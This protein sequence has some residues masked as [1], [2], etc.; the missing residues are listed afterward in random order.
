MPAPDPGV[1]PATKIV[2]LNVTGT[3]FPPPRFILADKAGT[4][5]VTDSMGNSITTFQFTGT[6]QHVALTS[7]NTLS[8][9]TKVWG[10]YS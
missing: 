5:T 10:F 7:I 3:A 6:E 9:T 1:G 4:G 8:T 2:A